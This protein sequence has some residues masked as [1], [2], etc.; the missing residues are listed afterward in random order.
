MTDTLFVIVLSSIFI[1]WERE[2][3]CTV[4]SFK[5]SVPLVQDYRLNIYNLLYNNTLRTQVEVSYT[6]RNRK[7]Y[8]MNLWYV[9]IIEIIIKTVTVLDWVSQMLIWI[10]A[11]MIWHTYWQLVQVKMCIFLYSPSSVAVL[12]IYNFNLNDYFLFQ[13]HNCN[14]KNNHGYLIKGKHS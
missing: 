13:W 1:V 12:C 7:H 3:P 4:K 8:I 6:G 11:G 9:F 14:I 2:Y 5:N 10:S